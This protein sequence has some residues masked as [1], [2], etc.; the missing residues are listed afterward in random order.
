MRCPHHSWREMHQSRMLFIQ[1]KKVLL[2]VSGTKLVLP[3]STASMAGLAS[4]S[5]LT[6]HCV[7][8]I[9]S[10]IVSQRWQWPTA[11]TCGLPPRSRPSSLSLALTALRASKRSS[12]A[13]GP[14]SALTTPVVV[15]DRDDR[16]LVALAGL[17]VVGIVRRRH[18]DRAG[19][20]LRVDQDRVGD[21]RELARQRTDAAPSCRSCALWRGSSGCTATAVSPSIVSGR[22]VATTTSPEPSA[23]GYANSYSS[24]CVALVVVDLEVRERRPARRAP[25]DEPARAVDQALFVQAH[26]R[27]DDR[28]RVRRLHREDRA[29]PVERAAEHA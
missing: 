9:G 13:N 24:P 26:E 29:V 27:L 14:P 2:Q 23:S 22:V 12:P 6:N 20:E 18:L 7:D 11:C 1:W 5:I 25:V 19:A 8:S 15:E 21:D 10:T 16:Q 17:E 3:C 28:R 4:G